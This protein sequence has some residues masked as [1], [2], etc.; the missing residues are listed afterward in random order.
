MSSITE[1]QIAEKPMTVATDEAINSLTDNR[2]P[3]QA[4][5]LRRL[6]GMLRSATH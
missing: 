6:N 4:V 1:A 3:R 5:S 2:Q